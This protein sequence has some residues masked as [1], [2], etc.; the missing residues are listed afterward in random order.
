V[1]VRITGI[2][3]DL[4]ETEALR[5]AI[6]AVIHRHAELW[7]C[8]VR[9]RVVGKMEGRKLLDLYGER[10]RLGLV[11]VRGRTVIETLRATKGAG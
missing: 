1:H 10:S 2:A 9:R 4:A 7:G 6:V 8:R 11:E 5:D 3:V